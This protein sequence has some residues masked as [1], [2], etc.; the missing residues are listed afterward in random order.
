MADN[1]EDAMKSL[2][3]FIELIWRRWLPPQGL[4]LG[5]PQLRYQDLLSDLKQGQ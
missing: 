3:A 1:A 4:K 2:K 5:Y